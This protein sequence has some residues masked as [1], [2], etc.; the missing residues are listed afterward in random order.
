MCILNSRSV[1]WLCFPISRY[2]LDLFLFFWNLDPVP[3]IYL[4]AG[5]GITHFLPRMV[6][7]LSPLVGLKLVLKATVP[8]GLLVLFRLPTKLERTFRFRILGRRILGE[9]VALGKSP[10]SYLFPPGKNP[11]EGQ[12]SNPKVGTQLIYG[13]G[14]T[15]YL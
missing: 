11:V 15:H 4:L 7:L 12:L 14:G 8:I 6:F 3:S 5:I 9:V 2:P 10:W 13:R 1:Q